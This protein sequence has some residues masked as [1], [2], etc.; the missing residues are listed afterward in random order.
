MLKYIVRRFLIFIPTLVAIS[1]LAFI[2]SINSPADPVEQLA[3]SATAEGNTNSE[4]SATEKIKNEIRERL[5]LNLPVFYFSVKTWADCDTLN[6]ISSKAQRESLTSLTRQYGNW[7]DIQTYHLQTQTCLQQINSIKQDSSSSETIANLRFSTISL[8]ETSEKSIIQNKIFELITGAN[9]INKK[10]LSESFYKLKTSFA[11]IENNSK[12]WLNYLPTLQLN[13]FNNQYH[14]WILGDLFTGKVRNRKGVIRGDFGNSYADNQPVIKKI[15]QTFLYSFVLVV[16][17]IV[18]AYVISI[19]LGIYAAYKADSLFDNVSSVIIFMLFSL[20]SFFVGTWLLYYF[21]NPDHFMWFPTG[22]VNDPAIFEESWSFWKKLVH[23]S[24]YFVLPIITY[25]YSSFAFTS[26][27]MKVSILDVLGQDY[28]RT[29]RA[30]GLSEY[31]VLTKHALKNA[32]LPMITMFANIFPAAVGGS[33]ILETIFSIPGMGSE[34][35]NAVVGTDIP[36]IVAVFT[37]TGFLTVIGYLFS[38]ILYALID[39]RIKYDN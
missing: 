12:T 4:S 20:P 28:I 6:N 34:I 16:I 11:S 1:L 25:T 9:H 24:P 18:M 38:D 2:I 33:V 19:P 30:K 39:P 32:M 21:A 26:R 7:E 36:M 37:I 22:G 29:A 14:I 23:Q 15:K 31:T 13:G 10:E 8:L 27:I 17:S 3:R 5:G 35:Y